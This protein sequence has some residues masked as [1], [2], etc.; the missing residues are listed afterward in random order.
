MVGNLAVIGTMVPRGVSIT[1]VGVIVLGDSWLDELLLASEA[2]SGFVKKCATTD[3]AGG[4][5]PSIM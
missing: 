4:V 5:Y 1:G 2:G 3:F